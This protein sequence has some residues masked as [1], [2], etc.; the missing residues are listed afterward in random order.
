MNCCCEIELNLGD[1]STIELNGCQGLEFEIQAP[2]GL[3]GISIETD[4]SIVILQGAAIVPTEQEENTVVEYDME[5]GSYDFGFVY[6][7]PALAN[8]E[9][10]WSSSA[11]YHSQGWFRSESW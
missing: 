6:V 8:I 7:G 11:W 10:E 1:G 3:Q 9:A 4:N 5:F 2:F